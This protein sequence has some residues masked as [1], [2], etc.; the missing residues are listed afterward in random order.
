MVI[1]K[2]MCFQYS[3]EST[4]QNIWNTFKYILQSIS[5]L[6]QT[7]PSKLNLQLNPCF[8]GSVNQNMEFL[9]IFFFKLLHWIAL[10]VTGAPNV[11]NTN[12]VFL[13]PNKWP[14]LKIKAVAP[15]S[16]SGSPQVSLQLS[17]IGHQLSQSQPRSLNW[18]FGPAL[19]PPVIQS[20]GLSQVKPAL[21]SQHCPKKRE[22]PTKPVLSL[23]KPCLLPLPSYSVSGAVFHLKKT[24]RIFSTN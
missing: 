4:V 8:S 23:G 24:D 20:G 3:C 18:Q 11:V 1:N 10:T 13:S 17:G 21:I 9:S 22:K 19:P 16:S 12:S 15:C 14:N 5:T 7:S 6:I 2:Y